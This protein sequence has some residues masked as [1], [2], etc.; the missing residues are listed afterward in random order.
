MRKIR[1]ITAEEE[2]FRL[3]TVQGFNIIRRDPIEPEPAGTIILIP[4]K[5]T[6]YD[7]DCDGSLMVRLAA[8]DSSGNETGWEVDS[9]GL[10]DDIGLVIELEELKSLFLRIMGTFLEISNLSPLIWITFILWTNC[11]H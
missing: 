4:F 2:N 3:E 5:I 7:P 11:S 9:I 8:I 1:E 6:G 10:Y